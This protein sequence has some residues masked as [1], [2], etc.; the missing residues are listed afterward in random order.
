M[1]V[2]VNYWNITGTRPHPSRLLGHL[3]RIFSIT[4][5]REFEIFRVFERSN[6][7]NNAKDLSTVSIYWNTVLPAAATIRVK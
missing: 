4:V 2:T 6:Y 1:A 7:V 5:N 3:A